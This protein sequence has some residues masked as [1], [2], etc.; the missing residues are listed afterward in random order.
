[1]NKLNTTIRQI[2]ATPEFRDKL[3]AL[4][5][6][7]DAGKTPAEVGKFVHA[8]AEKFAKVIKDRGIKPE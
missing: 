3:I 8:E 1:M 2:I 5:I 4:G 6:E 7:P